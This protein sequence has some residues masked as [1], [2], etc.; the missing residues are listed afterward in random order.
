MSGYLRE[1]LKDAE[2]LGF[3]FAGYDGN[4]HVRLRNEATGA[5]YP[6]PFSP[7]DWRSCKN[8]IAALE[9][10]SGRKLPRQRTGK[11]RHRR[12]TQLVT[13]LS[14]AE[15]QTSG[16]VAALLEEADS[17]RR[18]IAQLVAEPS[19]DAA[20]EARRAIAKYSQL[21]RRLEQL[22]HVLPPITAAL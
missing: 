19:R 3:T 4:N 8:N 22:H 12:Q 9:R 7:S 1:F 10:M 15:Q 5:T 16:Q 20:A 17:V 21:R 14:P 18:R 2:L 6:A 11:Y 13:E